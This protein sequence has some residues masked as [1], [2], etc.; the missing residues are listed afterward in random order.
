MGR[1]GT[2]DSWQQLPFIASSSSPN[3]SLGTLLIVGEGLTITI[4][5]TD[6]QDHSKWWSRRIQNRLCRILL[7]VKYLKTCGISD[8]QKSNLDTSLSSKCWQ[9]R[10]LA[11]HLFDIFLALFWPHLLPQSVFGR[12]LFWS[13]HLLLIY[14][15]ALVPR[16]VEEVTF[17]TYQSRTQER[18]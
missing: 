4:M 14:R 2:L 6:H 11:S 10:I 7:L 8:R 9:Q 1:S 15:S 16:L 17:K 12:Y 13:A 18:K 5:Y 3:A